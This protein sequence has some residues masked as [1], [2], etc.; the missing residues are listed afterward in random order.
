MRILHVT[1]RLSPFPSG[2]LEC[3]LTRAQAQAGHEVAIYTSDYM[4]DRKYIDS[5]DGVKVY[6]FRNLRDP[7]VF[8]SIT[9]GM[10]SRLRKEIKGFDIV[11]LHGY[12]IFQNVIACH[13][14]QKYN[15]PYILHPHGAIARK[16]GRKW[17][18]KVY[19]VF[20]G[21]RIINNASKVIAVSSVEL[22]T[23]EQIGIN[24]NKV[25]FIP[26]GLDIKS[27]DN[28]PQLGQF[29]EKNNLKGKRM[30]LFLGRIHKI[31][32]LDFLVEAYSELIKEIEDVILVFAGPDRGYEK[33]L[34]ELIKARNCQDKVRFTGY[35]GG[36]EKLS[37]F[38]DAN[39]LVNPSIF[40]N[41]GQAPLE[42]I[43]CGTPAIVTDNCGC[44]KWIKESG[45]G[46]LVKYGDVPG[47]KEKIREC[48]VDNAEV[49]SMVRQ[50]K[51]Y[52][53]DNLDWANIVRE[54]EETYEACIN[55]K[56]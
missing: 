25:A 2:E 31:K 15:I 52:I 26:T 55:D 20:F 42:A 41:F 18:N 49:K 8:G 32:G 24:Q 51:E 3:R 9:P 6:P 13:Y 22:D 39:V 34:R 4:L 29:K 43:M 44:A 23:L 35:I 45:A 21:Y 19:D 56:K 1:D 17:L 27:F 16:L 10:I 5:L 30:V 14:A 53:A 12:T 7:V 36:Q 54:Y 48:L 47:L 11:H 28:L 38:V 46:F 40:E 37:A 33:Q 50:G